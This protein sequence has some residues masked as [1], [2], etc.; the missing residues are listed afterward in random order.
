[1]RLAATGEGSV[2]AVIRPTSENTAWVDLKNRVQ[3]LAG[4]GDERGRLR[5]VSSAV[6]PTGGPEK[7]SLP[8]VLLAAA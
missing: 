4:I 1:M 7:S 3:A 6:A 8:Q 5:R 2:L